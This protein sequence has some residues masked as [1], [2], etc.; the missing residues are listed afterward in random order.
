ML[1]GELG[2][3]PLTINIKTRLINVWNRI[4]CGSH[5]KI[6]CQ[7]YKFILND[8]AY[9]YKWLNFGKTILNETGNGIIWTAQN[10]TMVKA[11]IESY[12]MTS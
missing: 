8:S 9:E 10:H 1:Y 3:Y 12:N 6:S 4:I 7:I 2:R 5:K 11:F